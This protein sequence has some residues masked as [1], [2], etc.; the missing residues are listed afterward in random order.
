[1]AV[2]IEAP[3]RQVWPWLVQMGRDRAGW[4]SWDRLDNGGVASADRIHPEWQDMS[5]GD[6]LLSTSDGEH[7]FEV[8]ALE[9]ERFLALRATFDIRGRQFA[10]GGLRPPAYT[11][12]TWSFLLK[13]FPEQ[14]TRLIVSGYGT[15]K[16]RLV[17]ALTSFLVWEPS[18]WIMQHRQFTN[19]KRRAEREAAGSTPT[20]AVP[21]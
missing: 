9:P 5:V 6:R 8:A 19:L 21:R 15:G 3:P 2:T 1:M 12:S 4:Y 7:W 20:A 10:S 17:Q 13:E 18:H 11:D 14:R 16:P